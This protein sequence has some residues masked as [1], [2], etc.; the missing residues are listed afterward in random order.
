MQIEVLRL[1]SGRH[2]AQQIRYLPSLSGRSIIARDVDFKSS[3][4]FHGLNSLLGRI[5]DTEGRERPSVA[6]TLRRNH[7]AIVEVGH[8]PR[9]PFATGI[10]HIVRQD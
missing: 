9:K 3:L 6:A 1:K 2:T 8:D 7:H 5:A 10:T 4:R